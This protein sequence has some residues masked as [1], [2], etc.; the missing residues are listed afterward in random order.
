MLKNSKVVITGH[1]DKQQ[2]FCG[3]C[4]K[5]QMHLDVTAIREMVF[6]DESRWNSIRGTKVD[7]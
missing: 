6:W 5:S 3:A 1:E 7:V 4:G 2:A